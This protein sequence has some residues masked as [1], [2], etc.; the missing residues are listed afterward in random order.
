MITNQELIAWGK[1]LLEK[2]EKIQLH[3]VN[4]KTKVIQ[5]LD[6]LREK[7]NISENTE[8]T[9]E[10]VELVMSLKE[11]EDLVP[12]GFKGTF[13][14]PEI[15]EEGVESSDLSKREVKRNNFNIRGNKLIKNQ[16]LLPYIYLFIFYLLRQSMKVFF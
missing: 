7:F 8:A 3:E 15:E 13:S 12:R 11:E 2:A 5:I 9:I 14:T 16:K 4:H 1:K 10:K 6:N